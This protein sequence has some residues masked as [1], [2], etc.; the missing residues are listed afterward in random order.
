[1]SDERVIYKYRDVYEQ[2]EHT[3]DVYIKAYGRDLISL[4]ENS[5]LAL[6]DTMVNIDRV[7]CC[8]ERPINVEGFDLENLLYRWLEELL[9]LYYSENLVCSRVV[10]KELKISRVETEFT[11]QL[12]GVACCEKF[13]SEK[14]E[15]RVEVKSPTYSLMRIVKTEDKWIAYFVLDI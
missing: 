14:H 1:M 3:G 12:K 2:L 13:N 11:Y 15:P 5:G 6:F 8:V 10:I 7:E 9:L 4:L